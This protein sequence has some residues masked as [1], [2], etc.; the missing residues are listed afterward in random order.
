MSPLVDIHIADF[1]LFI[2][3]YF[4]LSNKYI[5][6]AIKNIPTT[7]TKSN[8]NQRIVL[9]TISPKKSSYGVISEKVKINHICRLRRL[10]TSK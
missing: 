7:L 9:V 8:T 6:N 10:N 3:L 1:N 4:N 2:K 5:I